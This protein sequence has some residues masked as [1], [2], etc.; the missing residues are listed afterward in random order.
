MKKNLKYLL[1]LIFY[2]LWFPVH[3]FSQGEWNNWIFGRHCG[4]N[5]NSGIP[6]PISTVNS[7]FWANPSCAT[8]SDSTG[9]LLFY[10]NCF[11]TQYVYNR[12]ND[13]MPNGFLYGN[14]DANT[15]QVYFVVQNLTDDSSFYLFN[16]RSP[17][18][19]SGGL[20]Y[21]IINMRLDGGLGDIASGE[22]MIAV[23]GGNWAGFVITG[24]RHHNNKDVWIVT[25]NRHNSYNYLA[26]L[27]TASGINTTPVQ[28][29][30]TVFVNGILN[31]GICY[32]K[33]SPDGT[34]LVCLYDTVAEYC[35]FN[36]NTGVVTPLFH[37]N[38]LDGNLSQ[39][40][41]NCGAEWSVDNK[42][43][44]LTCEGGGPPQELFQFDA[45]KT[46]SALF[47]QSEV[48]IRSDYPFGFV[49]FQRGPDNKIY[50]PRNWLDSLDV[51]NNPS[52]QGLGCN[53]QKDAV[54]LLTGNNLVDGFPQFLQRYKVY[55]HLI[56]F[57]QDAPVVF[58]ADIWPPPDSLS[59]NF[60]DPA[61]GAG[62]FSNLP[63]PTH[64]YNNTG[65]YVVELFVRHID[66]RTD[67]TWQT[68]TI[69]ASP[70]VALGANKTI[71]I[72]DSAT[73]DAGACNGCTY[74][75]KILGTGLIVGTGQTYK[76]GL[77]DSYSV[78]VTNPNNCTGSDTV[79]LFTTPV[80][81]VTNNP[82][83]E[84]ICSGDSTYIV[85]TSSVPGTMFHWTAN[86]TSGNITGFSA[87][88]GLI[89]NQ[90]LIDN[91]PTNGVVTYNITPK[92][93]SCAGTSVAYQ[94]TVTPGVPV[95]ISISA[96]QN[97]VC[98]GTSVTFTAVP[99]NGGLSPSYQWKVNGVNTGP[100]SSTFTYTPIN[101]DVVTCVLTS[102]IMTCIINNPAT[103]NAI[104]ITVN[105]SQPVIVTVTP[106]QNPVCVELQ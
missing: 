41:D 15:Y 81:S 97:N 18:T 6:V 55:I 96:S 90:I 67:T 16:V 12:N 4:I 29:Q 59:W 85:L 92:V 102:S 53:Y 14:H 36:S 69:L 103:S 106:S 50:L 83:S 89:I 8:A 75:W 47:K 93:G 70:Q 2:E 65:S 72:G 76:T 88:S 64:L 66:N 52:I 26:Y 60:G 51:I 5:F 37:V 68:I 35:S 10:A 39:M 57:C 45:T 80:P 27:I 82:L 71:C 63:N 31:S 73:F 104:T 21:S 22:K 78:T 49:Q 86:L 77:A 13:T 79:Q 99:T 58:S 25:R 24:T 84:S 44:Y 46:D 34:K 38:C 33:I 87:D 43:L 20:F 74:Q 9:N 1:F 98:A 11:T 61:S 100:N 30:S 17:S 56:G 105:P 23:P 7:S 48:L 94:V 40:F 3:C 19:S 95:S 91:L 28:S 101:N 32:I 62:N 42:Y 54:C